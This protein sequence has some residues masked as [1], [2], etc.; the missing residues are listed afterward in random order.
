ML[1]LS[2]THPVFNKLQSFRVNMLTAQPLDHAVGNDALALLFILQPFQK[3]FSSVTLPQP[4][5]LHP[6]NTE[7]CRKSLLVRSLLQLVLQPVI[8]LGAFSG[9]PEKPSL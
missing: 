6:V 4:R 7:R 5:K 9:K 2:D 1:D 8:A 3:Q